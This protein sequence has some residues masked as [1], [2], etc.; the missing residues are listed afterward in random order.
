MT[1]KYIQ[2]RYIPKK[3]DKFQVFVL[4]REVRQPD[5]ER[6]KLH[7]GRSTYYGWPAQRADNCLCLSRS[8]FNGWWVRAVD[9]DG[10]KRLFERAAFYFVKKQKNK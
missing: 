1:K 10:N 2:N 3:G 8:N 4:T 5:N 9:G 7:I 6:Y